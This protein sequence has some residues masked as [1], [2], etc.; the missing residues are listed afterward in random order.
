MSI[1]KLTT[2]EQIITEF[3]QS[4]KDSNVSKESC[5]KACQEEFGQDG[6]TIAERLYKFNY[7]GMLTHK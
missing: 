3:A 2:K 1:P 7:F 6:V 5:I 4:L